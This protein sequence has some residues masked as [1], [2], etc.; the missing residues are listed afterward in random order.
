MGYRL[1]VGKLYGNK[2]IEYEFICVYFGAFDYKYR[3]L[4]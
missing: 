1:N 3:L 4:C 2:E